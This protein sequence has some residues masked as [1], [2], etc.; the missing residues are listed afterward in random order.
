[1]VITLYPLPFSY[2]FK[3]QLGGTVEISPRALEVLKPA[4]T[5]YGVKIK[6]TTVTEH[7]KWG[8]VETISF[9]IFQLS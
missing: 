5:L 3:L 9:Y 1:M 2:G 7:H 6:T 8:G 4:L